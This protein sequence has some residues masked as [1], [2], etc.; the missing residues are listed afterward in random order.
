MS[1]RKLVGIVDSNKMNKTV[2][3]RVESIKTHPKYLKR[4]KVSKK[5]SAHAENQYN[6]GDKVEIEESKPISKNKNWVVVKKLE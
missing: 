4:F 2:V 3:V 1:K 5:Y 6:I